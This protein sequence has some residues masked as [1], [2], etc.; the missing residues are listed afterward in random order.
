MLDLAKKIGDED[1]VRLAQKR[2][3][4]AKNNDKGVGNPLKVIFDKLDNARKRTEQATAQVVQA[5]E[6]L[7]YLEVAAMDAAKQSVQTQ[8]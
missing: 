1:M 3:D 7:A 4:E 5:R 8:V 6:K 2:L